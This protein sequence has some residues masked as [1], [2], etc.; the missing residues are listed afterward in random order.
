MIAVGY[1]FKKVASD[2]EWLG[3]DGVIDIYSVSDCISKYFG[4]YI[5]QWRHNEYWFFDSPKIMEE[6]ADNLKISLADTLLFYYEMHDQGF[7]SDAGQWVDL[8]VKQSEVE[9]PQ[10]KVLQGFDVVTYTFDTSPE[11]SPLSCNAL[12]KEIEVN[13]HCLLDTFDIAK[14]ALESGL[15]KNS[16]PGPYRIFAVYTLE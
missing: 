6:V 11:C 13:A 12:A 5:N 15:F 9:I 7:D 2:P 1:M 16:E 3:A 4:E 8:A 14:N 10:N